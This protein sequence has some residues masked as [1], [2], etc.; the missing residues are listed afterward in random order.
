MVR[1][2]SV[3]MNGC[4]DIGGFDYWRGL[5]EE[6]PEVSASRLAQQLNGLPSDLRSTVFAHVFSEAELVERFSASCAGPLA[7][8]PWVVKDLFD[9]AGIPTRAGSVFLES[10]RG[11]PERSAAVVEAIERLGGVLVGKTHL[12]EFAYGLTGENPHYGDCPNP[13]VPGALAGGSSSGSAFAVGAGIVPFA[14]GTDTAGSIRVPAAYCGIYGVRVPLAD[15]TA[16]GCFPLAP[17]FDAVG[18]FTQTAVDMLA[19]NDALLGQTPTDHAP[20]RVFD[21]LENTGAM[22]PELEDAAFELCSVLNSRVDRETSA[23]LGHNFVGA[24]MA[25]SIL[26]SREAF[27]LHNDW[28]QPHRDAYDP[29]VWGRIERASHW[30]ENELDLARIKQGGLRRAFEDV[31]ANYDAVIIPI[32]PIPSPTKEQ[33]TP[34]LRSQLLRFNTPVSLAGLPTL[35]IPLFTEKGLSGG[36]QV[37]FPSMERFRAAEVLAILSGT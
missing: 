17:S 6:G 11:V 20:L 29:V 8:V 16:Q 21:V 23:W 25:Y 22:D 31:F 36:V 7:G 37:A 30:S 34:D 33:M 14:I 3:S 4:G 15:W 18:W 27:G 10:I 5:F 32:S 12:N 1:S 24:E 19:L 26:S 13:R 9:V 28:L 2:W 35:A